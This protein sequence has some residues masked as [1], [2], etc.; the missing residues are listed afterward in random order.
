MP[1]NQYPCGFQP[2]LPLILPTLLPEEILNFPPCIYAPSRELNLEK[3]AVVE[4]GG[5]SWVTIR[6]RSAAT[7]P[8]PALRRPSGYQ[9]AAP[10]LQVRLRDGAGYAR[11]PLTVP[12]IK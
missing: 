5:E 7:L 10:G 1:E 2:H 4:A 8:Q 6:A 3:S 12:Y 9:V 11:T